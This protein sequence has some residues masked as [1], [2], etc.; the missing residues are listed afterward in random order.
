MNTT[1]HIALEVA[2]HW[3]SGHAAHSDRRHFEK[4]SLWRD[5]FPRDLGERLQTLPVGETVALECAAG[6]L[7]PE[8]SRSLIQR[9]PRSRFRSSPRPGLNVQPRVGRFYPATFIDTE[10][11]FRGDY[12]PARLLSLDAEHFEV[13]FNHPLA[14]YPL[15]IEATVVE[16]LGTAAERGGRCNDIAQDAAER[17]PG[18]QAP[19]PEGA[20]DFLSGD[21]FARMD[22]R[23][24][25]QFYAEPRRVHHLDATARAR[26]AALYG[27]FLRPGARVLD[28]MSSWTSHLPETPADLHV[29]GLGMNAQEL[30]ENPRLAERSVH[31]LN[32]DA[33]L[34]FADAAFDAVLCT[35]SVEYLVNPIEVFRDVARV[36]RPGAPFVVTF[37]ERWFPP[38][39]IELW[40][41]LHPFERMGLVLQYFQRAGGYAELATESLRGLPRPEDDKYAGQMAQ[42][43]PLYAVWGRRSL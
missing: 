39:A 36:L 21:P 35:A 29:T 11:L 38:K 40:S 10:L 7:V 3:Q 16:D 12:R 33:R 31:D 25:A 6:E 17:G 42:S 19:P 15:R 9:L 14:R 4:I 41:E 27:R 5:F 28:L 23:D 1:R 34:P 43:D 13:D 2:L 32:R 37:S 20:V 22:P 26:L 24:D 30:A 18:M 8:Y